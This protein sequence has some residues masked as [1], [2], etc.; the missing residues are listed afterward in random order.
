MATACPTTE[1]S[2][3]KAAKFGSKT[4]EKDVKSA[5]TSPEK[6]EEQSEATGN[7][8]EETMKSLLDEASRMLKSMNEGDV[9]EKR[10][11]G[12][13]AQERILGLQKQLD[14][15]K[16]A[17]MRPFRIYVPNGEQGLTGLR[18]NTPFASQKKGRTSSPSTKGQGDAGR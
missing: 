11:K 6:S 10:Q 1:E 5:T 15:L 18:G 16:K 9:K 3:P 7:G 12:E 14:E 2:K 13:D 8:G 17:S 4:A